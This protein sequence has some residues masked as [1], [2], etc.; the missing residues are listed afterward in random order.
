MESKLRSP[1]R[2]EKTRS[3]MGHPCDQRDLGVLPQQAAFWIMG[4]ES[5]KTMV[6][7][8]QSDDI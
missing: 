3:R 1:K 6:F 2:F 8:H 7:F 4:P 5:T